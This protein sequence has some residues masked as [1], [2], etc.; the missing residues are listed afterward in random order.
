LIKLNRLACPL[1][2]AL[3]TDYRNK[4]NKEALRSSSYGKCMYCESKVSHIDYGDVEHIKPK[5]IFPEHKYDWENL[6][7][8]CVKCNRE[9][10]KNRYDPKFIDPY[11]SNPEDFILAAVGIMISK[12]GNERGQITID[13]VGLNRPDLLEKRYTELMK[14]QRL[15][16]R[17]NAIDNHHQKEALIE[18]IE[19]EIKMDKEYS[20]SKKA[21]ADQNGINSGH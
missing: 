14:F 2:H 21:L 15:I 3:R 10:K 19:E 18:Q 20:L 12:D 6:G 8:A 16:E 17:Y 9:N 7:F 13:I 5:S 11:R 4:T 1:L